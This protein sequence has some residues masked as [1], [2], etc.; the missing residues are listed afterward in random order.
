MLMNNDNSENGEEDSDSD[1]STESKHI[2][3]ETR[4]SSRQTQP[5]AGDLYVAE[6]A[7]GRVSVFEQIATM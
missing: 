6:P 1:S 3:V 2:I 5:R 7:S 4:R